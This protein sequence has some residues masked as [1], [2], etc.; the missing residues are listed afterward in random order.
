MNKITITEA[1][2][3]AGISRQHLYRGFINT[4]KLSITKDNDKS[5]VEISELLRV[6]PDAKVV[7]DNGDTT[8]HEETIKDTSATS[9]NNELVTVLKLQL[10]EAQEREMWL[11]KQIDELRQQQNHLLENKVIK[12]RKKFLGIF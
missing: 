11:K 5:V 4:G 1:A 10:A 9:N 3:L 6:F 8:Q 12:S 7:T 2:R